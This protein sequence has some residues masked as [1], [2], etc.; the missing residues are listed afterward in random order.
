MQLGVEMEFWVVDE[1]G[2]LCDGHDLTEAHELAIPEFV[3]SL[4][5]VTTPPRGSPAG[6]AESLADVLDTLLVRAR[7][8]D[9]RLVPLGTPLTTTDSPV[10]SARGDVLE[11]IYGEGLD[12][13]KNCAG[14]H[15]HFEQ[16]VVARQLNLLTALDPALA[17]VSSSPFYGGERLATSSRAYAYRY[18]AGHDVG[19]FRDL[20]AYT[21]DPE[22][23]DQ[24]LQ[25]LYEELRSM[26]LNRGVTV[27]EYVDLFDPEDVVVT[28]VRLR[29]ETPTVEWRSPDTTLPSQVV[30]L[31]EDLEPLV[32]K[33]AD[34]P[35]EVG[36]PGVTNDAI[37]VP[38][39]AELQ[40]LS[41][42]AIERGLDSPFV[43]KYLEAY[44]IDTTRYHPLA[45]QFYAGD[46]IGE[47]RARRVRLEAAR[48]LER[49]V[50]ALYTTVT[51]RR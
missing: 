30:T 38:A 15:V 51:E 11:R 12:V 23:W 42:A 19:K 7:E 5:E 39:Y 8:T 44:G 3:E 31:L 41:S 49:D 28:P 20:W 17:L 27:E 36:D 26:A 33:T 34:L 4:V 25:H 10:V 14:T 37:G 45:D 9:R 40:Q 43:W 13:A 18:K 50:D 22:Q 2:D 29:R 48:L 6:I 35:V 16:G 46:T 1:L 47:E 24:R 21:D 32:A